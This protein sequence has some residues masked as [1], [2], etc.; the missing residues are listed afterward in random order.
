MDKAADDVALI[1][2][3]GQPYE[4]LVGS[5]V[6]SRSPPGQSGAHRSRLAKAAA[7][8]SARPITKPARWPWAM[9]P[10]I[11]V[12]DADARFHHVPNLYAA[13]PSLFPTV[14][15]PNPM[16]TGTAL[17][18]R[19]ADHLADAL[20]RPTPAFTSLF[21]GASLQHWNMSTIRNQPG[22]DDPGRFIVTNGA[23]VAI[24]GTDIGLLW[25]DQP[26]PPDF[27]LKLEWRRWQDDANSGV[28][29]RFP[30]P[31]TRNYD[32]TAFVGVDF[33]FEVQIDQLAAPDG[34][35]IHK[36]AA[37]LRLPGAQQSGT[38]CRST[39]SATGTCSRSPCRDRTTRCA[40]RHRGHGVRL[41]GRQRRRA[42]G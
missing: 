27:V 38:R 18:R 4:V 22:R 36:T 9:I 1:F 24:P 14:G 37:D 25:H 21:D 12:T 32:N 15:S 23:L 10:A 19:L 29:L 34:L 40:Q 41:R 17:A 35:P 20:R 30:N 5:A 28:F 8:G 26:T 3:N 33:G 39:R 2:A 31:E 16:L 7:T 42:S 6:S 11:S 13:G